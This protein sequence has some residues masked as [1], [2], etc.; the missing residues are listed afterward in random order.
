MSEA[1]VG[2]EI[3][4]MADKEK[5]SVYVRVK[6]GAGNSFLCPIHALKDPREAT[7]EELENCVDDAVVARYAGKIK[8][9]DK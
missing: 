9:L 6:D 2:G 4:I 1:L 8:V 7:D 5:Q 3:T